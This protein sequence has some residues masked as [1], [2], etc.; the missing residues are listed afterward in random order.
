[1]NNIVLFSTQKIPESGTDSM[2]FYF[3]AALQVAWKFFLGF[4]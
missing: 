2:L 1:M 4:D 3:H